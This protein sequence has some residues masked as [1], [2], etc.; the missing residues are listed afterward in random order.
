MHRP[1]VIAV[2]LC[3]LAAAF[4]AVAVPVHPVEVV[5]THPHDRHAFTQGLAWHADRLYESTGLYGRSTLRIVDL[6]SGRV[7]RH[8]ALDHRE[9]G[10]DI[11][12]LDGRL[13]QLT[14]HNQRAYVY[15][16]D[17]LKR[18][19]R[20]RYAGEG[21]GLT[22]DGERLIAS[23][24]SATLRFFDPRS[25][26]ETRRLEVTAAGEPLDMLNA[27]ETVDG[28]IYANVW[29]T[30]RIAEIDPANGE[31]LAFIE[32]AP[33]LEHLDFAPDLAVESPNGIAFDPDARRLFVTGKLWPLLF[34]VRIRR[35][36]AHWP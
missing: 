1:T 36:G 10:E 29:Q 17:T 31:V 9:F 27:L 25:F 8:F 22:H 7:L 20:F 18:T 3:A 5:R 4:A 12:V 11:T 34:E 21:W 28:R 35:D 15:D 23:D 13:Y 24:G 30:T 32:L 14:W 2:A 33:L 6:E 16:P 26:R 19:G